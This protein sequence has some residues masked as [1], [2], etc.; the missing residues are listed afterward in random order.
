MTA[1]PTPPGRFGYSNVGTAGTGAGGSFTT[2]KPVRTGSTFPA[3]QGTDSGFWT[4]FYTA[5]G[6]SQ[7]PASGQLWPRGY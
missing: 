4:G 7:I 1:F 2:P 3:T 6:V 5:T